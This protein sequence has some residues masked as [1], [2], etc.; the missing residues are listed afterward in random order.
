MRSL[1]TVCPIGAT[2]WRVMLADRDDPALQLDGD[3]CDAVTLTDE[4]VIVIDRSVKRS[5]IPGLVVHEL[6]H[7]VIASSRLGVNQRWSDAREEVIVQTLAD[8]MTH[9]L[10]GGGLWKGRRIS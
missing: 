2:E 6:L 8:G 1:Y 10:V 4:C 9:A 5:R 7:A 3:P